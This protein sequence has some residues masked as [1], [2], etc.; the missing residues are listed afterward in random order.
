MPFPGYDKDPF[1][2]IAEA[3]KEWERKR[4]AKK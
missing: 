4:K 3:Q 2:Q 1:K